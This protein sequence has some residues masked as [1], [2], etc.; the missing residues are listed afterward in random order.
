MRGDSA[1]PRLRQRSAR[2][3]ATPGTGSG[4]GWTRPLSPSL[5]RRGRTR[6][7]GR[8]MRS[9]KRS[10][11]ALIGVMALALSVTVGLLS[12]SVADAKKKK[13][14]TGT[15]TATVQATNV[16]V[17]DKAPPATSVDGRVD[18]PLTISGKKFKQ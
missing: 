13:K 7:K 1:W 4:L 16:A 2:K 12:G 9:S 14:K 8:V 3:F 11:V 5:S 10:R 17:P 15:V 6:Q 18:I